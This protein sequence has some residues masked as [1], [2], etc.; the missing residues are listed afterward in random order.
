MTNHLSNN[1][2]SMEE[3]IREIELQKERNLVFYNILTGFIESAKKN[4]SLEPENYQI[5]MN[6]FLGDYFDKDFDH[7]FGHCSTKMID[8]LNLLRNKLR[9]YLNISV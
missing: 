7:A 5:L 1:L 6:V 2:D 4:G 9:E 8:Y 3:L